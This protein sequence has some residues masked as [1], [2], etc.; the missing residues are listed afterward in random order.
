[1]WRFISYCFFW[2]PQ[3][4][5]CSCL[6]QNKTIRVT[7]LCL[8]CAVVMNT[9]TF[10]KTNTFTTAKHSCTLCQE[11]YQGFSSTQT[12]SRPD[13]WC[14]SCGATLHL[15]SV[16]FKEA[17]NY[18]HGAVFKNNFYYYLRGP[19]AG[20]LS[21]LGVELTFVHLNCTKPV[22]MFNTTFDEVTMF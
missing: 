12:V 1:M 2:K 11:H 22:S 4:A 21:V 19:C 9:W 8:C 6:V 7:R 5:Q 18:S 14:W 20:F 10:P 15:L 16:S 13:E 17:N 3:R